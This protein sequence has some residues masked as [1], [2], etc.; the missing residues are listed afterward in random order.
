MKKLLLFSVA[1]CCFGQQDILRIATGPRFDLGRN[2]SW[3][4]AGVGGMDNNWIFNTGTFQQPV[5]GMCLFVRNR[6]T[7]NGHTITAN[8]FINGDTSDPI[9]FA[10]NP[11]AWTPAGNATDAIALAAAPGNGSMQGLYFAVAGAVHVAVVV[12]DNGVAGGTADM[13]VTQAA[14]AGLNGTCVPQNQTFTVVVGPGG[15]GSPGAVQ[16]GGQITNATGS[17]QG[18]FSDT[19]Y[20]ITVGGVVQGGALVVSKP[21]EWSVVSAPASGSQAQA[22]KAAQANNR[23]VIDCIVFSANSTAAVTATDVTLSVL[24]GATPI[25]SA[26]TALLA[27]AGTGSFVLN[28][29]SPSNGICGLNIV[30]SVNTAMTGQFSAGVT[31][32]AEVVTMTGYDIQ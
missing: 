22:V 5:T 14:G 26:N 16:I 13:Y 24:D 20:T 32:A 9:S 30:G 8:A 19:G 15:A 27:A 17:N 11:G 23:H 3:N 4:T 10:G 7:T 31:G 28:G 21:V 2:L 29:V 1:L 12:S 6:D 18:V 25:W